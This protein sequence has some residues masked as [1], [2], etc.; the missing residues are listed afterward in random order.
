VVRSY[1]PTQTTYEVVFAFT[2]LALFS[3]D[4][5]P[6]DVGL[7]PFMFTAVFEDE[8]IWPPPLGTCGN[9]QATAECVCCP[10]VFVT[11][12]PT[13][14]VRPLALPHTA[15]AVAVASDPLA[16]FMST[17]HVFLLKGKVELML[18]AVLPELEY[19]P[20]PRI[21]VVPGHVTETEVW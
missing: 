16:L 12:E 6:L 15:Y 21:L 18:T 11:A 19:P 20:P 14:F 1:A 5:Q 10:A 4:S 7:V 13:T 17:R 3:H 9:G 8:D 2:P